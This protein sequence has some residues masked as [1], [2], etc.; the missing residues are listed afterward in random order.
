M[1]LPKTEAR[2][3][4]IDLEIFLTQFQSC[5]LCWKLDLL[6]LLNRRIYRVSDLHGNYIRKGVK[7]NKSGGEFKE[8]T[9][10]RSLN[11]RIS[12]C[13]SLHKP[14]FLVRRG[15]DFD[16]SRQ[17]RTI[18]SSQP[19]AKWISQTVVFQVKR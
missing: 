15:L 9:T 13:P 11:Q 2:E 16:I 17:K 6:L 5:Y 12:F 3:E 19:G 10:Q 7:C 8:D 14:D 18:S 1:L 4:M